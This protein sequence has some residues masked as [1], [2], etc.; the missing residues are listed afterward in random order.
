[1]FRKAH[2]AFGKLIYNYTQ[3]PISTRLKPQYNR[4]MQATHFVRRVLGLHYYE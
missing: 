3:E 1:M 2:K 4:H